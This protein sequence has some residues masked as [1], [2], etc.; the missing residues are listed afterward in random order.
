[1]IKKVPTLPP[2]LNSIVSRMLEPDLTVRYRTVREALDELDSMGEKRK[3]NTVEIK[4]I[5]KRLEARE[6]R[7]EIV[8]WNCRKS[9]PSRLHKC[10]YCGEEQ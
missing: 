4:E 10:L 3:D 7:T 6:Q 8:C 9:M 1:L 2:E 5:K